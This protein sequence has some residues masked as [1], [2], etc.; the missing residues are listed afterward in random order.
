MKSR[1]RLRDHG[2]DLGE[3]LCTVVEAHY[4]RNKIPVEMMSAVLLSLTETTLMM[5][6]MTSEEAI[7]DMK[8]RLEVRA[9]TVQIE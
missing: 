6:G 5:Y 3:A 8:M 4:K 1:N 9:G 7:E 2:C